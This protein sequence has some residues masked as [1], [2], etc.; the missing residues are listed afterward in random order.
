MHKSHS[1]HIRQVLKNEINGLT[2][3]EIHERLPHIV[4]KKSIRR[5]LSFMP[6]VYIDRWKDPKRGQYQA[7]YCVVIK[8]EDCP[9]PNSRYEQPKTRWISPY[10]TT[11]ANC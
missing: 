10:P 7:V 4:N 8:P 9:H 6:D 5:A 3:N 2:I 11:G 1:K